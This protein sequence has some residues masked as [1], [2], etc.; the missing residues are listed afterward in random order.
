LAA[1]INIFFESRDDL[2]GKKGMAKKANKTRLDLRDISNEEQSEDFFQLLKTVQECKSSGKNGNPIRAAKL[3]RPR[4]DKM[5]ILR[6]VDYLLDKGILK[7]SVNT[8][9]MRHLSPDFYN[10]KWQPYFFP[11]PD[12]LVARYVKETRGVE[13]HTN[14]DS[15]SLFEGMVIDL[16]LTLSK[17]ESPEIIVSQGRTIAEFAKVYM[18]EFEKFPPLKALKDSKGNDKPIFLPASG[19]FAPTSQLTTEYYEYFY[20]QSSNEIAKSLNKAMGKPTLRLSAPAIIPIPDGPAEAGIRQIDELKAVYK[21][22]HG[23]ASVYEREGYLKDGIKTALF[24]FGTPLDSKDRISI[25]KFL[26]EYDPVLNR[27]IRPIPKEE[28]HP[29]LKEETPE[30]L[31]EILFRFFRAGKLVGSEMDFTTPGL[32][33]L[34]KRLGMLYRGYLGLKE[35]ACRRLAMKHRT[36]KMAGSPLGGLGSVCIALEPEKMKSLLLAIL[37]PPENSDDGTSGCFINSVYM[38]D[39]C[40]MQLGTAM[41]SLPAGYKNDFQ[42]WK[43]QKVAEKTAAKSGSL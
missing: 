25:T 3:S 43:N 27:E 40:K 32:S 31:D 24:T 33:L 29:I 5:R 4:A 1:I 20:N 16:S 12:R 26:K 39:E 8:D 35:S 21:K 2:C 13:F 30:K 42:K 23:Y 7:L 18:R 34:E 41:E 14:A 37:K 17:G 38:L 9:A 10:E 15:D 11:E 28:I 22:E 6:K 36:K 19:N